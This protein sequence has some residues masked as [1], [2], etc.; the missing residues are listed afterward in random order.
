MAGGF[1]LTLRKVGYSEVAVWLPAS[2][3]GMNLN[4]NMQPFVRR[5]SGASEERRQP[6][7]K[8]TG[9]EASASRLALY[10]L[11]SQLMDLQNRILDPARSGT[12]FAA[13][14][15][16]M[17]ASF[18]GVGS[19]HFIRALDH[20]RAERRGDAVKE[21]QEAIMLAPK[22]SDFVALL[23]A[24]DPTSAIT[25]EFARGVTG[26]GTP[27][28]GGSDSQDPEGGSEP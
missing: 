24:I 15:N 25:P 7:P 26:E 14:I 19:L 12:D 2:L 3:I 11:T 5:D 23:N 28:E 20:L 16:A 21:L 13:E 27:P 6:G 8:I 22:E 9:R 4:L 18:R 10:N 17:Q 1:Y